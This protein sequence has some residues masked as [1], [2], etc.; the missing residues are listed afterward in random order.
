MK[1][2]KYYGIFKSDVG[3]TYQLEVRCNGFIQAFF[4]LT[5]DAIRSGR[6]YQLHTILDEKNN[7]RKVDDIIKVGDVI[8]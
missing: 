3:P 1:N 8:K 5:A 4:L 2:S 6:H 7:V